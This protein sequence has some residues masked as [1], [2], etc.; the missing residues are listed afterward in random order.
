M[1][2]IT[3]YGFVVEP[4]VP[5]GMPGI[6]LAERELYTGKHH[7]LRGPKCFVVE[8]SVPDGIGRLSNKLFENLKKLKCV[9]LNGSLFTRRRVSKMRVKAVQNVEHA[10]DPTLPGLLSLPRLP[11][12]SV[13]GVQNE[14]KRCPK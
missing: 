8:P 1:L 12:H 2:C 10:A 13:Q 5:D 9:V 6:P 11:I 4:S 3:C 14:G 7:A